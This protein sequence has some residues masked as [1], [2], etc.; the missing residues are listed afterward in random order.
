MISAEQHQGRAVSVVAEGQVLRDPLGAE[1]DTRR[2]EASDLT[3]S[4][5]HIAARRGDNAADGVVVDA[6]GL[7][8]V[9]GFIDLQING[10][11]GHDITTDPASLWT[12]GHRLTAT[13]T[14]AFLPTVVSSSTQARTAALD[15]L[16]DRPNGYLGAEPL[17]LH[18]EGPLLNPGR[19]GAHRPDALSEVAD[20]DHTSW[21]AA[22]GVRMVTLAPELDGALDCIEG[23]VARGVVVAAGHTAAAASEA[24]AA[25]RV[26][27][28]AVTHLFNAMASFGHRSPNLVGYTLGS[29]SSSLAAGVIA[30]GIHLDPLAVSTAWRALGPQRLFL[31]TDAVAAAGMTAASLADDPVTLERRRVT[32]D[33]TGVRLPDGTLAGSALT[34][35][36]A[37]R[38]MR[39][40]TGCTVS[41]A[42]AVAS[43]TPAGVIR[44]LQRGRLVTGAIADV[45]LLDME[46]RP[47][48]TICQG[49]LAWI[50]EL[51]HS[52]IQPL[53]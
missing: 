11:F 52:R 34:M 45:V 17:G 24:E 12:L 13:G 47:V 2:W 21:S 50:D 42:I 46:L 43:T 9:P 35:D 37:V 3:I 39:Q 32:V 29:T 38:N 53:H 40:F 44:E 51:H 23:L 5:G 8:V 26:G 14:T 33:E 7:Y 22:S 10:G 16:R 30:D 1:E 4:D 15:A 20:I 28:S 36:Q 25:E 48:V 18:F 6:S 19:G 41:E 31:V 27:L 49:R